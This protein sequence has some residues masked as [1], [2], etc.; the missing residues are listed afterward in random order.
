MMNKNLLAVS[1]GL[2]FALGIVGCNSDKLTALNKNPNSPEDVPAT[3]LFTHGAV[4]SVYRWLG[5]GYDLRG[6][7]FVVQHLA[8]VQYPD[9]DRYAR[10]T[11]GSTTYMF[12]PAYVSELEDLQKVVQKGVATKQAGVYG[13]ALALRTWGFGYLTDTWGDIPYFDALKG[14]TAGGSLAPKYDQQKL[15]YDDFFKV[16]DQATKDMASSSVAGNIGVG[17]PIYGGNLAQWQKFANSLRARFALRL[18]NVDPVTADAQLRAAIAAPGGLI[19]SNSD[20]AQLTFPGDG[21]YDNPWAENFKTRDDHRMS[22]VLMNLMKANNDPR[23]PIFAQPNQVDGTYT[24]APNA[25]LASD[26]TAYLKGA[27]RPGAVFY[28]GVTAYGTFG[29]CG[30][31]FPAFMLTAAEVNFILAEAAARSIGGLTPA[32]APGYYTAGITASMQMWGVTDQPTIASYL[33]RPNI[34]YAAGNQGLIRIAQQKYITL[35]SDGGQAWAEWRRTCQPATIQPGPAAIRSTVPRRFMYSITEVSVN[36]ANVTAAIAQQGPDAFET[37]MYWDSKPT[38]SPT[39]FANCG[40]RG[41]APA[42]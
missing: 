20:N 34:V 16:L 31:A 37:R 32:Q 4:S 30:A 10:L 35:F 1:S 6:T 13:P 2:A 42:P 17:D 22:I 19:T 40:I 29:C 38:A 27:S 7:E 25:L 12:D 24:G 14:D 39:W 15:I 9:E 28:P 8:E 26:I 33:A 23:I 41:L 5:G 3:T 18:I 11:G 36:G 21:I